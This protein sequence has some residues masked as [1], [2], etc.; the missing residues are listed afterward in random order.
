MDVRSTAA[1]VITSLHCEE[2]DTVEVGGNLVTV[3]TSAEPPTIGAAKSAADAAPALDAAVPATAALVPAA[4]LPIAGTCASPAVPS[5]KTSK[6]VQSARAAMR[7]TSAS[8]T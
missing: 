1:G 7:A 8:S 6:R 2:G 5:K 3:D 4:A